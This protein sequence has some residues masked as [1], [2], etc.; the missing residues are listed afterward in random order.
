[1]IFCVIRV[2][3]FF[4][5]CG[6]LIFFFFMVY[7]FLISAKLWIAATFYGSNSK[8]NDGRFL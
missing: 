8:W 2:V 1:M 6:D 3:L 4:V 5:F 7:V